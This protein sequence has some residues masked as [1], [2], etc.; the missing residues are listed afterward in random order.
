[1][2]GVHEGTDFATQAA[3][4]VVFAMIANVFFA[5]ALYLCLPKVGLWMAFL[6]AGAVFL[7]VVIGLMKTGLLGS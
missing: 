7:A 1:L 4:G 6:I 5:L 3:R 2:I